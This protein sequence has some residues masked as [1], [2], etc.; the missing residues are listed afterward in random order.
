MIKVISMDEWAKLII[1]NAS[2]L[3]KLLEN[4]DYNE[5]LVCAVDIVS[6]LADNITFDAR[7]SKSE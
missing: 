3:V 7:M 4:K 6:E 1:E 5:A 2:E